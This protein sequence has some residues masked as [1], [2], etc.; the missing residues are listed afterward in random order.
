MPPSA[1]AAAD[2]ISERQ[3]VFNCRDY[4][5]LAISDLGAL[6]QRTINIKGYEHDVDAGL[7]LQ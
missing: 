6:Y 5:G 3:S 4:R 1:A 7:V 2:R